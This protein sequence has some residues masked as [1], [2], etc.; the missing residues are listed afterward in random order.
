MIDFDECLNYLKEHGSSK[1]IIA[2]FLSI[3]CS[4]NDMGLPTPDL[5]LTDDG[6]LVIAYDNGDFVFAI[7]VIESDDMIIEVFWRNRKTNFS[8]GFEV[9][10]FDANDFPELK[11]FR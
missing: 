4:L 1:K 9:G 8:D 2:S 3:S 10:A 7:D 5:G 11:R 6:D